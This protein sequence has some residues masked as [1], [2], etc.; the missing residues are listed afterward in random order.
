MYS[1]ISYGA[2]PGRR[3][4]HDQG[5]GRRTTRATGGAVSRQHLQFLLVELQ[6]QL[7]VTSLSQAGTLRGFAFCCGFSH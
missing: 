7:A 3:A 1:L 2:R 6:F 4:A 5:D